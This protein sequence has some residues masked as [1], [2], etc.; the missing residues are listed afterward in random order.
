MCKVDNEKLFGIIDNYK[1]EIFELSDYLAQNFE[2]SG[3][4]YNSSKYIAKFLRSKDLDVE[5]PFKDEETAFKCTSKRY[6]KENTRK[7]AILAEY[8]A[9]PEIGHACGHNNSC[10]ISILTMLAVRDYIEENTDFQIDL[11]G[12][13]D[14]EVG[15]GKIRLLNKHAFDEY[16]YTIMAHMFKSNVS[17]VKLLATSD[18]EATFIG[19]PSHASQSP[20]T[21]RN[22]LNA[23]QL[24]FNAIDM[25]RQQT[26]EDTRI[27]GIIKE[28][29][30][31]VNIIPEK[32]VAYNCQRALT[33]DTLEDV[34][35][36][37]RDCAKG[38]ALATQTEV[39]INEDF[40]RYGDISYKPT[41]NNLLNTI[42][43]EL[44][45]EYEKKAVV[46]GS[47]DIGNV[48]K[49][50][51]CIHPLVYIGK[52]NVDLHTKEL[53]ELTK[54]EL[55]HNAIINATKLLSKFI[56]STINDTKLIDNI[57]KEHKQYRKL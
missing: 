18:I 50:I 36:R 35:S 7:I 54:S 2:V 51:P 48:D 55:G 41:A 27:H 16:E 30:T 38:A 45:L 52:D 31:L 39:I 43:E 28:G 23:L 1:F 47:S 53:E 21:G 3:K 42:F 5:I 19:K 46:L 6:R 13:P 33:L 29:G 49:Y 8:D 24:Y 26:T 40:V 4:E 25:M 14:E 20:W 32:T 15:G 17:D 10:A 44:G 9:L 37:M 57:K 34:T 22:A 12:T 56:I 11:I